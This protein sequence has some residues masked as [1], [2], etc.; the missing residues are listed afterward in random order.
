MLAATERT[1]NLRPASNS[2]CAVPRRQ[3]AQGV[4]RQ[5]ISV[6]KACSGPS[7]ACTVHACRRIHQLGAPLL[8]VTARARRPHCS[9]RAS[10]SMADTVGKP[11]E[12]KAAI[13]WEAQKPLDV[14][15]VTVAPPGPGEV[16]LKVVATALCHTVRTYHTCLREAHHLRT[17]HALCA[18]FLH[19]GWLGPGGCVRCHVA[20]SARH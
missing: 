12:C 16:R 17:R 20:A 10:I 13:A 7:S 9:T 5:R 19:L 8:T 15:T 4:S 14:T 18:G 1:L 2:I 6:I 3:L 11:I